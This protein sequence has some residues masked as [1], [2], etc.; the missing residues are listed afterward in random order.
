MSFPSRKA[1]KHY[2]E[3]NGWKPVRLKHKGK[4]C[5]HTNWKTRQYAEE[6]FKERDNIGL[7]LI[8]GLVDVDC[9]CPEAVHFA[10]ALLPIGAAI[11]GR[12]SRLRSHW[13]YHSE[14]I[15]KLKAHKDLVDGSTVVE[16]R[17]GHQSMVPPSVHPSGEAIEWDV[18]W[19]WPTSCA[20]VDGKLLDRTVKLIAT[21]AMMARHYPPPGARHEWGLHLSGYLRSLGVN[22]H[23]AERL[24]T[25]AAK[26]VDDLE[27]R[28]RLDAVSSTYANPDDA[29]V[30]G[31]KRLA[32]NL[33]NGVG[34]KFVESIGTVWGSQTKDLEQ[35]LVDKMNDKHA[36]LFRQSGR[37]TILTEA[38]E[39]G[40]LQLRYTTQREFGLLYPRKVQV[41]TNKTGSPI[42]KPMG[43]MWIEHPKRRYYSGIEMAP[44]N[45]HKGYYNLWRG[46]TVEPKQ[47]DW[48]LFREHLA[49][50]AENNED[51][52]NYIIQ[53]MAE[54]V[55]NP[56]VP[57]GIALTFRGRQ[58]TGKTSAGCWFGEL[59]GP[60]FM[61]LDSERRVLGNFNAHLHDKLL[62]VADEAV[63]AGGCLLYTSDAA[64]E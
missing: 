57:I 38:E 1:A 26:Y 34:E 46:S 54:T 60:H 33:P 20:K 16:L 14:A 39:D 2:I 37:V 53:W 21:G 51:H 5:V 28:D 42:M 10:N 59:F 12:A 55:Q 29:P 6:D 35:S 62:I 3:V 4:A 9:D 15:K 61:L 32:E 8:D 50:L 41:G 63:W 7:K 47:G 25:S 13:L 58:G 30:T 56:D 48:G 44:K 19:P 18:S 23:E 36:I 49:L 31:S 40:R 24:F 43:Q 45:P 64:D 17:V 11:Y 52:L 27:V 22:Q